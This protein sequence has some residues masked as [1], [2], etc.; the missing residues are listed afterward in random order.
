MVVKVSGIEDKCSE[1]QKGQR[2]KVKVEIYFTLI[3]SHYYF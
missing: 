2:M 3:A 1:D